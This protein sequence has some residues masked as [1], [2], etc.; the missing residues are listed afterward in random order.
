MRSSQDKILTTL[1][2]DIASKDPRLKD[3]RRRFRDL[4]PKVNLLRRQ[5]PEVTLSHLF[6]LN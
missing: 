3:L 1:A 5:T 6:S 2:A 4:T